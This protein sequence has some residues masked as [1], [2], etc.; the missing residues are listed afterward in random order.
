MIKILSIFLFILLP[1]FSNPVLIDGTKDTYKLNSHIYYYEDKTGNLTIQ[2]I[3][4][5]E[6][7][8]EFQLNKKEVPSF[9]ITKSAYWFFIE[10]EAKE[11]LENYLLEIE[12]PLLDNIT[13]SYR[14][15]KAELIQKIVGDTFPFSQ[16]DIEHRNFLFP[17]RDINQNGK[18]FF[19]ISSD[20]SMQV[21]ISI[22]KQNYFWEK[23]QKF[24]ALQMLFLGIMGAMILYNA[25][26]G[27]SLNDKTYFFYIFY[28]ISATLFET[29]LNGISYQF[30]WKDFTY[31]NQ[32][33]IPVFIS[34]TNF[35]I[36]AFI[37][38]FLKLRNNLPI[39]NKLFLALLVFSVISFLLCFYLPYSKVV[40]IAMIFTA[41]SSILSLIAAFLIAKKGYRPAKIYLFAWC[42][43]LA[44]ALLLALNRFQVVPVNF[45]T[46][47]MAQIGI[48][49]EAILISF[50]LADRIKILQREK[51]KAQEEY[52]ALFNNLNVGA[53]RNTGGKNGNFLKANPAI[54]RMF[55]FDNVEEFM[56]MQV[57]DLYAHPE[58]RI[59]FVEMMK[60]NRECNK[61]ELL[62][63]RKDQSLFYAS[64]TAKIYYD[65]DNKYYY[66]DGII[67]DITKFKEAERKLEKIQIE[68]METLRKTF[69]MESEL[70]LFKNEMDLAKKIQ[71]SMIPNKTP[72]VDGFDIVAWYKP[73]ESIGGDF[74]DFQT[75][76]SYLGFI[77]ADVSGHGVPAA[78]IVSTFKIAFW[79][80]DQILPKPLW[81]QE[82]ALPKPEVLLSSMNKILKGKSGNE[83]VTA[84]YGYIDIKRKILKTGNAG[85]S[86]LLIYRS[87]E[88]KLI[89]LNPK[90]AAL[91][92][93]K[94]P[95]FESV[96]IQLEKGDRIFLYTDGLFEVMNEQEEVFGEAR[97]IKMLEE[98]I[99]LSAQEFGDLLLNSVFV[100]AKDKDHLEDDIALIVIDVTI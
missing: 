4:K 94:D 87:K 33:S 77:L 53:Y 61:Y 49:I 17:L 41:L 70:S 30:F 10:Y 50:A 26:L 16:R 38:S 6:I 72:Q 66:M 23:D 39:F 19:R 64:L 86:D 46:E 12:Y 42:I 80:Q 31:W 22:H 65:N 90:G 56:K 21:P 73:M 85:H 45:F 98:N 88:S 36:S 62:L 52:I 25:L 35:G 68:A 13:Y 91:C 55:G 8:K 9:G 78:L 20:G 76:G 93:F 29:S 11:G 69:Q 24:L 57:S 58:E 59:K 28:L 47:N 37:K 3:E 40:K 51:E 44:G 15:S 67:E 96:D 18:L 1:L 63:K 95:Q 81:F 48:G 89:S 74:Y 92:V 54:A 2:D 99:S 75:K 82:Q 71:Q 5:E 84:C 14:N 43:F 97:L 100:W 60:E 32:I 34:L 83:F 7:L 27:L 79:F